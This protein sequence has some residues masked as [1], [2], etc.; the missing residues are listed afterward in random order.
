MPCFVTAQQYIMLVTG[1]EPGAVS[2]VSGYHVPLPPGTQDDSELPQLRQRATHYERGEL[3]PD[4]ITITS[5][6]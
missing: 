1:E 4:K 3:C 6:H 5:L 2:A